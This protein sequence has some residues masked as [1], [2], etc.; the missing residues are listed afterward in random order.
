MGDQVKVSG[1]GLHALAD[2]CDATAAALTGNINPS[3]GGLPRQ[4][5]TTAVQQGSSLVEI[6]ATVLA[7]RVTETAK[8]LRVSAAAYASTD[9]GAANRIAGTGHSVEA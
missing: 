4:A 3:S 5:T 9:D 8:K 6:A 1:E 7:T 2:Q